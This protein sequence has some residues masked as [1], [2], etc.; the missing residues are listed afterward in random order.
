MSAS[1]M[2]VTWIGIVRLREVVVGIEV[3]TSNGREMRF[4]GRLKED[5]GTPAYAAQDGIRASHGCGDDRLREWNDC[6]PYC[7]CDDT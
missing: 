5:V 7:R 2:R 1:D 4:S 6:G 3:M